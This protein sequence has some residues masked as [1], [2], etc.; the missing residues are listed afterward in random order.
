MVS[1]MQDGL[2]TGKSGIEMVQGRITRAYSSERIRKNGW[3]RLQQEN[4]KTW[5][6]LGWWEW[7]RHEETSPEY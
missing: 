5:C 7:R 4:D 1:V 2:N 6:L 3:K